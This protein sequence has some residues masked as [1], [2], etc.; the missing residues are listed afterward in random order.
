MNKIITLLTISF[1]LLLVSCEDCI[2][3]NNNIITENR[4]S[5]IGAITGIEADGKFDITIEQATENKVEVVGD[6]NILPYIHTTKRNSKLFIETE[7][8]K[9]YSSKETVKIYIKSKEITYVKLDNSA[10]LECRAIT[11]SNLELVLAGSGDINI[12]N[13][14]IGKLT[15]KNDG[16][17]NI[18]LKSGSAD[19]T[20]LTNNSS[21][22]IDG[23][24]LIQTTVEATNN[25]SGKISVYFIESLNA[26]I[27]GSGN[28]YYFGDKSKITIKDEGNGDVIKSN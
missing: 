2:D 17:G 10:T 13:M 14:N 21:G 22:N 24:T 12:Y 7:S 11:A 9:C 5:N 3:G 6:D 8:G 18:N 23:Q 15:T 4:S 1:V 20:I 26:R 19:E 25:G 28:I 27:F 16:T